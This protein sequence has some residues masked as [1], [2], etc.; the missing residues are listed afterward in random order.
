LAA[1]DIQLSHR[2]FGQGRP[3]LVFH[4][5]PGV[6]HTSISP[7]LDDL[8][9]ALRLVYFDPSGC[10]QSPRPADVEELTV[11]R[12]MADAEAVRRALGLE[13]MVVAGHS[14]GGCLALEYALAH[15]DRVAGAVVWGCAPSFFDPEAPARAQARQLP[16]ALAALQAAASG[17][18][19]EDSA[20]SGLVR[21]ALPLYLYRPDPRLVDALAARVVGSAATWN[22]VYT[23][24][25]PSYTLAHRLGAVRCPVLVMAGRHDWLVPPAQAQRLLDELP[26]AELSVLE[27]SGHFAHEEEPARFA[28][29]VREWLRRLPAP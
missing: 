23:R 15:P 17:N 12:W 11:E 18:V 22:H 16:A 14:F 25:V 2:V 7:A 8:A 24:M 27:E 29:T 4:G 10:G 9:D 3:A 20:L 19:A 5:L 6:S 28:S 1:P 21:D 13:A 26:R